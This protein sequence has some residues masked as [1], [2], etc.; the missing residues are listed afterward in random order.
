MVKRQKVWMYKPTRESKPKVPDIIKNNLKIKADNFIE[1]IL[2]PKHIKPP[3][4]DET[5]NYLVDIYS[6][7]YQHYFYF[8]GKYRSPGPYAISPFFEDKF[9]RLEYLN[10]GHFNLS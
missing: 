5:F 1:T 6:K 7:W 10:N 3:P 4:K 8:I 9:A 2:K